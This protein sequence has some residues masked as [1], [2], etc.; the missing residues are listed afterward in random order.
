MTKIHSVGSSFI[1]LYNQWADEEMYCYYGNCRIH[2]KAQ[3]FT[4]FLHLLHPIHMHKHY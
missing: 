1:S 3:Y 2:T 4:L